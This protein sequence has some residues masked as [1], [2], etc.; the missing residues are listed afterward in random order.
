MT[1]N[2][3]AYKTYDPVTGET[4]YDASSSSLSFHKINLKY[5]LNYGILKNGN[6]DFSVG[7][8]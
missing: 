6:L 8:F 7:D 2:A 1:K 3:V 4:Y 5:D